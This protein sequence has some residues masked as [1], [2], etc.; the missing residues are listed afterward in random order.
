MRGPLGE[1]RLGALMDERVRWRS[2][3]WKRRVTAGEDDIVDILAGVGLNRVDLDQKVTTLSGGQ[4]SR[5]A[6]AWLLFQQSQLLLLDEPTN[7][8]DEEAVAWLGKYLSTV[9]QSVLVISARAGLSG[10]RGEPHSPAGEQRRGEVLSRQLLPIPQP[11][12]PAGPHAAA[13]GDETADRDRAP[14][15]DH[16]DRDQPAQLRT[17]ARAREGGRQA[18]AAGEKP[19]QVAPREDHVLP[20]KTPLHSS[21]V[22]AQDICK[23]FGEKRVLNQ[24]P[25]EV[26]RRR[27]GPD[28]GE[29]RGKDD[30]AAHHHGGLAGGHRHRAPESQPR[31]GL[32][33]PGVGGPGRPHTPSGRRSRPSVSARLNT[34]ARAGALP[35]RRQA[36]QPASRHPQPR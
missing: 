10:S 8:I 1:S 31:L 30:A 21:A 23:S 22:F 25:P 6:L 35:L 24:D 7:H 12:R 34:C 14:E 26:G 18:A 32:V 2:S 4:K 28:W 13:C 29:R 20:T 33:S 17:S 9:P 36:A 15:G 5:L 3:S 16:Q 19:A 27:G 11:S